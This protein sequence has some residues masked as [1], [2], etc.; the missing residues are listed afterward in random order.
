[1]SAVAKILAGLCICPVVAAPPAMLHKPTRDRI[2]KSA[3]YVPAKKKA[4]A[5]AAKRPAALAQTP[6]C[7]PVV[8]PAAPLAA[9]GDLAPLGE[10]PG[11]TSPLAALLGPGPSS[12][13]L[14]SASTTPGLPGSPGSSGPGPESP[15]PPS[16]LLPPASPVP[17]PA[18]WLTMMIGFGAIGG[19]TRYRAQAGRT[20]RDKAA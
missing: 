12:A 4:P 8:T 9:L 13:P 17:E 3:G 11:I 5:E 20:D 14:R 16:V 15:E 19:A 10:A 7:P 6:E 18:T 2:A 1:M